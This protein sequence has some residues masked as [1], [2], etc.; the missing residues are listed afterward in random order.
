MSFLRL[1]RWPAA[2]VALATTGMALSMASA[3]AAGADLQQDV[4]YECEWKSGPRLPAKVQLSAGAMDYNENVLYIY[5]GQNEANDVQN[6]LM[7]VDFGTAAQPNQAT[8]A[9]LT[10]GPI[11]RVAA[12]GFYRPSK[13]ADKKGSVYFLFGSRDLGYPAAAGGSGNREGN[14]EDDVIQYDIEAGS[15]RQ[16]N[17]S[18]QALRERLLASAVYDRENDV[19]IVT[20]GIKKCAVEDFLPP[21]LGGNG[22]S[23]RPTQFPTL[24]LSFDDQGDITV[25]AG[26]AGGPTNLIGHTMN[27]DP[28]NKRVLV[29]GGSTDGSKA[30][31]TTWALSTTDLSTA[32]WERLGS[33]GPALGLH[34]SAYNPDLNW[35]L[36]HGG[37]V[38]NLLLPSETVN[39]DTY[40]LAA[41]AMGA[42][43]WDDLDAQ[44]APADRV[45]HVGGWVSNGQM[46]GFAVA[47]G[48]RKNSR[49]GSATIVQDTAV[50]TCAEVAAPPTA[51]MAPPTA[52]TDPSQPTPTPDMAP[53]T[54]TPIS[55]SEGI[56]VCASV[57]G[58]VPGAARNAAAGNPQGVAGYNMACNPN[59][60]SN[61][62]TNPLRKSLGLRNPN[63]PYHPIYNG[64]VLKCGCP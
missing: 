50:L 56:Q 54:A 27:Y 22:Q 28:T 17:V 62:V 3:P 30:I 16:V 53:P 14:G 12:T 5:G 38:A 48:R 43:A 29:H 19:A 11:E 21:N 15:W 44:T 47:A 37:G 55:P 7:S 10:P 26:P 51:T 35:L 63:L 60:P 25:A 20:G 42:A 8:S 32:S 2:V 45:N 39:N 64:L 36:V 41:P 40:G 61:P 31:N 23:C 59:V 33:G 52:T 6:S 24:V 9:R 4:S 57:E 58:K 34:S 13:E 18:G 46:S 49:D 1:M